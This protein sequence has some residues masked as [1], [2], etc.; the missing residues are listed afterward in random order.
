MQVAF[1]YFYMIIY[2]T[3]KN[4]TSEFMAEVVLTS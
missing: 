4:F 3:R 1:V 2:N